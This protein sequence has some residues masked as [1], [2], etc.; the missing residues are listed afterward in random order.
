LKRFAH[1]ENGG[2]E[3]LK[4]HAAKHSRLCFLSR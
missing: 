3:L 4:E 1:K 2:E